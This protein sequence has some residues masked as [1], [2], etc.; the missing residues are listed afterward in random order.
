MMGNCSVIPVC[1][2]CRV[3]PVRIDYRCEV[4]IRYYRG[5]CSVRIDDSGDVSIIDYDGVSPIWIDY[6]CDVSI[7]YCCGVCSVRIDDSGDIA[8]IDNDG[9]SPIWIDHYSMLCVCR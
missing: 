7:P 1:Y 5:V 4:S 3:S 9:V 6:R 8:V 2:G